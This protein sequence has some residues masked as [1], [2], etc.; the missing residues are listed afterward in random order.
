MTARLA[1][2][3]VWAAA[4]LIAGPGV[5]SAADPLGPALERLADRIRE[6]QVL[7][8][9]KLGVRDFPMIAGRVTELGAHVAN[10]LDVELTRRAGAGGYEIVSRT[11]LCEVMREN[12]LSVDDRF[13]ALNKKLGRLSQADFLVT[14]QLTPLAQRLSVTVRVLE[15]ETGRAVWADLLSV[16]LDE[17]LNALLGRASLPENCGGPTPASPTPASSESARPSEDRLQVKIWTD[18]SSYRIGDTVQFGLRV[19]RDAY[20]TLVDIGTSG[21]VT[22]V[23]PNRF[24]PSHF[25][26]AGQDVVI[27]PP[28]SGFTLTVQGP[29]GFDQIRVIATEEPV[30]LHASD[31]AGQG[32]ATFRSL[33]QVQTRNLAV[34]IKEERDRVA[35]SKWAEDAIRVEI[36]R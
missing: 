15:P 32:G 13:E 11:Q 12:A 24:S 4:A 20:V 7:K 14:G 5:A 25:V 9:K 23:F 33:D 10:Q 16:P 34:V 27:P 19:N 22:I 17:G 8:G 26:R 2:L 1:R 29:A 36:N 3:L 18:K 31:F 28:N 35:P 21:D 6:V 30:K